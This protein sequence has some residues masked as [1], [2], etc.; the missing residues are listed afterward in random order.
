[1]ETK[2]VKPES[3]LLPSPELL[4]REMDR[5][6]AYASVRLLN[7]QKN[8]KTLRGSSH[9]PSSALLGH[10]I[11]LWGKSCLWSCLCHYV[12]TFK[13]SSAY[14]FRSLRSHSRINQNHCVSPRGICTSPCWNYIWLR[15]PWDL[16]HTQ[17]AQFN[18][19]THEVVFAVTMR[20]E[21][22]WT[23]SITTRCHW[24]P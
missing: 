12:T 16:S 5:E 24:Y 2:H 10:L 4:L 6:N 11:L 15:N 8:L 13:V 14:W 3:A 7:R 20:R 22:F 23:L 21:T 9:P 19:Q 1:M 18:S 17:T